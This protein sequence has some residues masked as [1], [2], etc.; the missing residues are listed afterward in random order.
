M[1]SGTTIQITMTAVS[2]NVPTINQSTCLSMRL[3][4]GIAQDLAIYRQSE[5]GGFSP[6]KGQRP[7]QPAPAKIGGKHPVGKH[8]AQPGGDAVR[9]VRGDQPTGFADELRQRTAV[10]DD[11]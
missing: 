9:I 8:L 6:R 11:H 3:V 5:F 10:R 4:F 1:V 7:R 2:S